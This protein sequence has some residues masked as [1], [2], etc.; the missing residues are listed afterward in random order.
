MSTLPSALLWLDR[1]DLLL[2][3]GLRPVVWKYLLEGYPGEA[4]M[5]GLMDVLSNAI[6]SSLSPPR[7]SSHHSAAQS[8]GLAAILMNP[9]ETEARLKAP[10]AV[11]EDVGSSLAFE[12]K[13]PPSLVAQGWAA[14]LPPS[15]VKPN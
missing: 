6:P 14:D 13:P 4:A 9:L 8:P 15:T 3:I 10:Q 2:E 11:M 1:Q 12:R 5:L 7:T